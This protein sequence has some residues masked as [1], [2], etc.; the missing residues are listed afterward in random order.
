[1]NVASFT[2]VAIRPKWI[3]AL[4]LALAVASIFA[5]LAQWQIDR[6]YRYVPKTPVN[7]S[8][9]PLESLAKSSSVFL[10]KQADRLVTANGTFV[11]GI[12]GYV[13]ENR[14]QILSG[15]EHVN[16][17]WVARWLK[18]DS[19]KWLLVATDWFENRSKAIDS[20]ASDSSL[21][22]T[23]IH[24]SGIYEPG[25]EAFPSDGLVFP[26]LSIA[27]LINQPLLPDSMD[28]YSGFLILEQQP[29]SV[30]QIVIGNNPGES[31]FNWLT[32]FYALE[33]TLFAGFAIFLWGRL[34]ADEV[35]RLATDG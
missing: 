33:W 2:K 3:G 28:A 14:I 8:A 17:F 24:I 1:M 26:S 7:Q 13:I 16:G 23:P 10:P 18:T 31:I 9:V 34:V 30:S 27:Q 4:F 29:K 11:A 12:N 25:E 35:N 19:D 22:P 20:A 15:G 5:L 32:A 21:D 6:S